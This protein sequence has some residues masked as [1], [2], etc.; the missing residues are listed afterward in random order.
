MSLNSL[1]QL[2][3]AILAQPQWEKQRRFHELVKCWYQIISIKVAQNT[4][5][6]G[7]REDTLLISTSGSVWSQNLSLQRYHLLQKINRLVSQPIQDLHFSSCRWY[8]YTA[9]TETEPDM[10]KVHPSLVKKDSSLTESKLEQSPSAQ[11]SN[12]QEAM[13]RWWENLQRKSQSFPLCPNCQ[14]FTPPGELTRW[15]VCSCCFAQQSSRINPSN[16]ST[17]PFED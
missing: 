1:D 8:P 15:G 17:P 16:R 7:L 9:T 13:T 4:R 14:A 6:Y 10:S 5:P 2:L 12:P 11:I 3:K